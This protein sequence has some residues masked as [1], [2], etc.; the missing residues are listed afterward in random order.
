MSFFAENEYATYHIQE[1]ILHIVYK[2][3]VSIDLAVAI[4]T[5]EDRLALQEGLSFKII[6]DIRGVCQI[7]KAARDYLAKEGSVLVT[8]VAYLIEPT[9]T[10]AISDFY[11]H[12]SNPPI[13]SKSFTDME[14]A[15]SFLKG[16]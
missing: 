10:R 8:A 16:I 15:E 1:D 6:C 11:I 2:P 3:G 14:T 13:P 5:V 4:R 7:N 9:V 12:I